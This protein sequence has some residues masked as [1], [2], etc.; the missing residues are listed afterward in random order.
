[1]RAMQRCSSNSSSENSKPNA[2]ISCKHFSLRLIALSSS[3]YRIVH[4]G[5][6]DT[7]LCIDTKMSMCIHTALLILDGVSVPESR[8]SVLLLLLLQCIHFISFVL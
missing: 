4:R 1:M 6:N 3:L 7:G 5:D 8:L 2:L